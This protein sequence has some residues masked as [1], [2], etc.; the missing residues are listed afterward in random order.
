MEFGSCVQWLYLSWYQQ[1]I[2]QLISTV[3]ISVDINYWTCSFFYQWKPYSLYINVLFCID[4]NSLYRVH[5]SVGFTAFSFQ[6][7]DNSPVINIRKIGIPNFWFKRR[8]YQYRF[9]FHKSILFS[10]IPG[11][12]F[13]HSSHD[14][15]FWGCIRIYWSCL[16]HWE[17][18]PLECRC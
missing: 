12:V 14:Y 9:Q 5:K 8:R 1:W 6:G 11:F 18:Y 15:Y 17:R 10:H 4:I 13:F 3:D 16:Y 2:S 7:P